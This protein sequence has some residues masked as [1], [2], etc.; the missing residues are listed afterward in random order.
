MTVEDHAGP[1]LVHARLRRDRPAQALARVL[2][3]QEDGARLGAAHSLVWALFAD[4]PDRRRDFLWRETRPGEFLILATRQPADHHDLF[5]LEHKPF[6]PTLYTGQRLR[7]DL[8]VN[9]VISVPAGPGSRGKRRDVVTAALARLDAPERAAARE[10]TIRE[11]AALW[12]V[13]RAVGAGFRIDPGEVLIAAEEWVRIPRERGRPVAFSA[14]TIKGALTV[15]D[16]PRFLAA[17]IAGFGAAKAFGCGLML[18][19]RA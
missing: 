4:A 10:E 3:P 11:V 7:F 5:L 15:V 2:V 17:M 16:A 18:I 1:F 19:R 9:A 6:A 12:L 14:L 13:K 8:R